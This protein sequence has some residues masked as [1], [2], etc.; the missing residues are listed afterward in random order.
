MSIDHPERFR[1]MC[2]QLCS[3]LGWQLRPNG[4]HVPLAAGRGQVVALELFEYR[5]EVLVRLST[6]IG[7]SDGPARAR[8]GVAMRLNA[9]VPHGC[10]AIRDGE[11]V[12]TDT[13]L[14]ADANPGELEASLRYLAEA[15]DRSELEIFGTDDH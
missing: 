6:V 3:E 8:L 13:L 1:N 12:M 11:L 5:D 9:E 7:P 14:F 10:F 4:I 15:A 2:E